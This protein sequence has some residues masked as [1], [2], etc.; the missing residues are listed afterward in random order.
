M[1]D[2]SSAVSTVES[3]EA[4]KAAWRVAMM[5]VSMGLL[6]AA[7]KAVWRVEKKAAKTELQRVEMKVVEKVVPRAVRLV[8][9]WAFGKVDSMVA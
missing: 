9:K 1:M 3:T 4:L 2:K 8:L 7:R 6:M 5:A